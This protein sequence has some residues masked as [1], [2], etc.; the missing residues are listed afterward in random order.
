MPEY[1]SFHPLGDINNA[2]FDEIGMISYEDSG[3][4]NPSIR[5]IFGKENWSDIDL[6]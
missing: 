3:R 5:I 1:S 4:N 2:G 6:S